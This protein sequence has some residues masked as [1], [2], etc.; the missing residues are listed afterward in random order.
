MA[1]IGFNRLHHVITQ[2][3]QNQNI[4]VE[5]LGITQEEYDDLTT[6]CFDMA[7]IKNLGGS[8]AANRGGVSTHQSSIL[9]T[10]EQLDIFPYLARN[11]FNEQVVGRNMVL[12]I[13]IRL[14]HN[15]MLYLA[16]ENYGDNVPI[17]TY[18]VTNE[19]TQNR[20][21]VGCPSLDGDAYVEFYQSLSA[22]DSL[23]V[24]KIRGRFEYVVLA[25]KASD[26]TNYLQNNE[27]NGTFT[28]FRAV[29]KI[30]RNSTVTPITVENIMDQQQDMCVEQE[31]GQNGLLFGINKLIYGAPGTG[32]SYGVNADYYN[33]RYA[34]RVT[35]HPEYT[36]SDFIG[37]IKPVVTNSS[38]IVTYEMAQ[39]RSLSY[40]FVAGPFTEILLRAFEDENSMYTLIIEELNRGNAVAI[41][42]ELFQLLDR[43]SESAIS[44]YPVYNREVY[45]YI[46][47]RLGEECPLVDGQVYIP[48]NLNIIA[49]MN[50]ADQNVFVMDTAFKRRWDYEYIPVVFGCD[51]LYKDSLIANSNI[52]WES[53]VTNINEFMLSEECEELLIAE[54]KQ[55]GPYFAK[56]SEI[57]DAS[58][59]ANKVLG[60]LWDDV[61]KMDRYRLFKTNIR[62]FSQLLTQF[63]SGGFERVFNAEGINKLYSQ[64]DNERRGLSYVA[65]TPTL[66]HGERLLGDEEN[67]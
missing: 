67:E 14:M 13:P 36:Y 66:G 65:E 55:L 44:E 21:E 17:N 38:E 45:E 1:S 53:F 43:D 25:I 58:K 15:N 28:Y 7:L 2:L 37:Y 4:R 30:T 26:K 11:T 5:D 56:A 31:K 12:R 41:F 47:R 57:N 64:V 52:S 50:A 51:H 48:R 19:A 10:G 29:K 60:Y 49:T 39:E 42:G 3:L 24:L 59:F 33:P 32:K 61:F 16:D 40:E 23:I 18:L 27:V 46:R 63:R 62:S 34:V 54:D 22:G 6:P 20:L 35:F 8:N 9:L